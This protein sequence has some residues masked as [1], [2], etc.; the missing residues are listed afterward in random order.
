MGKLS[1]FPIH[2][3]DRHLLASVPW[4]L[5]EPH[6]SQCQRNHYQSPEQLAE[7]GGLSLVELYYV[8]SGLPFPPSGFLS[9]EECLTRI[10]AA[11]EES[12]A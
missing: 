9:T 2:P 6:R 12:N 8:I 5:V 11:L 1:E 10:R 4:S 3:S 7:R